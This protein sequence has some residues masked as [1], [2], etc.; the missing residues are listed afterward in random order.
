M[1]EQFFDLKLKLNTN[2][3]SKRLS[4]I[5]NLQFITNKLKFRRQTFFLAL[6]YIDLIYTNKNLDLKPEMLGLTCLILAG[7]I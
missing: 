6:F 3:L 2:Y 1:K 7:K 4:V 5:K